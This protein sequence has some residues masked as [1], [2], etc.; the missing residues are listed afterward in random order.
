MIAVKSPLFKPGRILGTPGAIEALEQS[1]QN[2]WEFLS[3]HLAG[4]WGDVLDV[5]DKNANDEALKDGSRILSAYILKTGVKIWIITEA[6]DDNGNRA[7][8]TA[9]L[10]DEY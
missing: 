9:L 1:G 5:E 6:A 4:A 3:L 10:P 2:L 8:T 7:A